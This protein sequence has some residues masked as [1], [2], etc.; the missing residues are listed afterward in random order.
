MP[1]VLAVL[2]LAV[3]ASLLRGG[4]LR[5]LETARLA[6]TWLLVAGILVQFGTPL[7]AG[8]GLVPVLWGTGPLPALVGQLAV[9]GWLGANR[10]RAGTG[11]LAIGVVLNIAGTLAATGLLTGAAGT[12]LAAAGVT[13]TLERGTFRLVVSLGD[14]VLAAGVVVLTNTLMMHRPPAE[15]RRRLAD[16]HRR[17]HAL[18]V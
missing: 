11:L 5:G 9:L 8:I 2:P 6:G 16:E 1:V 12:T 18:S 17:T 3:I 14:V 10:H 13:T 15:R 4:R 7:A